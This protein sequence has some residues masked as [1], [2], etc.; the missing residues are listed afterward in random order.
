MN[1]ERAA[2]AERAVDGDAAV[3]G[4][5]DVLDDGQP[6][7]GAAQL[8]AASAID[9]VEALEDARQVLGRDAAAA[10][11]DVDQH[12]AIGDLAGDVA[13]RGPARCT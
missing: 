1:G 7:A 4:L 9:A 6:Q 3:M 5:H 8:A 11:C 13:L 2:D 10:I 12:L